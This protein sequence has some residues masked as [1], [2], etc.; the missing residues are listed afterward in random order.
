ML[1]LEVILP[2]VFLDRTGHKS[3]EVKNWAPQPAITYARIEDD[4]EQKKLELAEEHKGN[5][6]ELEDTH[7]ELQDQRNKL[8]ED[9]VE[10]LIQKL[11]RRVVR[12]FLT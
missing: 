1:S 7:K 6:A 11:P 12:E 2:E 10:K 9:V 5:T 3:L 8:V 4:H